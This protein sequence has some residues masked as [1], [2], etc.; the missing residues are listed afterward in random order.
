[1]QG[2]RQF[3][4]SWLRTRVAPG[5][6]PRRMDLGRARLEP[7]YR[8]QN[9]RGV[10]GAATARKLL[11]KPASPLGLHHGRFD[12]FEVGRAHALRWRNQEPSPDG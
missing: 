11:E 7:F 6:L 12:G 4:Q 10:F 5:K 1:M 3:P 2:L 9:T 8:S